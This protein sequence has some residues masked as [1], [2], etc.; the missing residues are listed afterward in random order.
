LLVP[1]QDKPDRRIIEGIDK[2]DVFF[3]RKAKDIFNALVFG[4]CP[5]TLVMRFN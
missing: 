2:V 3:P 5:S 1:D 4:W